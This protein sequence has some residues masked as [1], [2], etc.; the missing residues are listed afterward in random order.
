NPITGGEGSG[1]IVKREGD[2]VY[3]LT[4]KHILEQTNEATVE[5]FEGRTTPVAR[6]SGV[7]VIER[8]SN[9]DLAI[10][11][12]NWKNQPDVID[13]CPDKKI[14]TFEKKGFTVATVGCTDGLWP[15]VRIEDVEDVVDLRRDDNS[16][17]G[18]HWRTRQEA[19]KGRSG[20]PMIDVNGYLI[21]ICSGA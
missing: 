14:D 12:M 19:K 6:D 9:L 1:V 15:E 5:T 10:L 8:I 20:G 4:A 16:S 17:A 11:K 7:P 13:I 3:I 2:Y 21:G 18:L